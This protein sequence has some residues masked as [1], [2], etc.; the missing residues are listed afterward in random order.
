[1]TNAMHREEWLQVIRREY[2]ES[3][4]KDG[5]AAVKFLVTKS[6]QDRGALVKDLRGNAEGE[7]YFFVPIDAMTTKVHWVDRL[8]NAVARQVAWDD[9][10]Y[11][12]LRGTL[13]EG[14]YAV[15]DEQKDFSLAGLALCNSLEIGE[16]RRA[17]N[18]RLRERLFKDYAMTQEFRM[19]MMGLCRFQ[20]E[21]GDSS[22]NVAESI[23]QWLCGELR[24]ISALKPALIFHKIGRHNGRHML[25]SLS[26]WLHMCGKT[27]L[28]L[29]LDISR[30]LQAKSKGAQEPDGSQYYTP[31]AVIDGYEVF[32]QFIDGTDELQHCFIAVLAPDSFMSPDE[33]KRGLRA[34]DALRLRV[35]DEVFDRQR[36]N[37]LSSLVRLRPDVP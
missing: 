4:V 11:A 35:Y 2:L 29:S 8:F 17:V 14:G 24:L 26:H 19:A 20:L 9:L 10:A 28:A 21:P 22:A 5:G 34:Y 6:E 32:R 33:D 16:M 15:P 12:F 36:P 3:F 37:P 1:M 13:S 23:R 25:F 7:N 31:S 27:G 30:F 18:D